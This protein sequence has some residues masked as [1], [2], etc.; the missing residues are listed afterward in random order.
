MD[1]S[2]LE[3]HPEVHRTGI[4]YDLKSLFAF[5]LRVT[6]PRHAREKM[7]TIHFIGRVKFTAGV[8]VA[9]LVSN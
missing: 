2:E 6:D 5:F 1:Y 7:Y 3:P 9:Q 4:L 8:A